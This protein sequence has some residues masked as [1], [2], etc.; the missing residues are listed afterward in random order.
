MA[1]A[2]DENGA[3]PTL[4]APLR[5]VELLIK[6]EGV[7][8]PKIVDFDTHTNKKDWLSG[9][10]NNW[11]KL[12]P[13]L[14]NF[15]IVISDNLVE[16]LLIRPDAWI[17]G[18]FF[19]HESL[20]YSSEDMKNDSLKL[21]CKY[22]PRVIS[23]EFFTSNEVRHNTRLFEVGLYAAQTFNRKQ[24]D[25]KDVLIACGKG[26]SVKTQ[27]REFVKFI[28][29]KEKTRFHR[30]WVEPDILP[31]KYPD[32]MMPAKFTHEM[33]QSVLAAV[34]RP[35]VGTVTNSLLSGARIFSFYESDN[36]EMKLNASRVQLY[37]VGEDASTIDSAW[38]QAE[39]FVVDKKSQLEHFKTVKNIN[40]NGAQQAAH[41]ILN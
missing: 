37:K 14:S 24:N 6:S 11:I 20:K 35:G 5:A 31:H 29:T 30:V 13:D 26:G 10:A 33:F 34:I 36:N 39:L 18:S 3:S 41:I 9:T 4:F 23:S 2:L 22:K 27:T 32:W 19:W 1:H 15:D 38:H 16:V 17:S 8:C 25:K 40:I 28:A 21:L 12:I 7:V